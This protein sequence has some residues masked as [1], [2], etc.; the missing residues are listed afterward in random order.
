MGENTAI[1]K[2]FQSS[3]SKPESADSKDVKK[4]ID[5]YPYVNALWFLY[6]RLGV[7]NGVMTQ[8]SDTKKR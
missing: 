4:L 6:A 2:L 7:A 5:Q 8:K 3:L 1:Q